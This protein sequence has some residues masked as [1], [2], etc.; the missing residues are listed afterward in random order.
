MKLSFN[1]DELERLESLLPESAKSLVLIL[2]YAATARL[3]SRF[4]GVTLSAKTGLAKERS[5]GVH[6]MLRDVLNDDELKKL[7]DYLGGDQFYIPRCDVAFRKLRDARFVAAIAE[8]LDKGLSTR[9]AMARLCPEFNISDR[10]GWKL[11]HQHNA[12]SSNHQQ[13][14]F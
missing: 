4:G 10:Q 3:I 6:T 13:N 12:D 1:R 2:G 8:N 5:G 7:I 11:I 9:Q 14:L